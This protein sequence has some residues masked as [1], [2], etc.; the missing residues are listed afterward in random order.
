MMAN[1]V[2]KYSNEK[3]A[4]AKRYFNKIPPIDQ[5]K[6]QRVLRNEYVEKFESV[7]KAS[8]DSS[9]KV[10]YEGRLRYKKLVNELN[11]P[12]GTF[13]REIFTRIYPLK[14]YP[15][16]I[17]AIQK[18]LSSGV[19]FYDYRVEAYTPPGDFGTEIAWLIRYESL[20][21]AKS[22]ENAADMWYNKDEFSF[23]TKNEY[24]APLEPIRA[25]LVNMN[26]G[27]GDPVFV[28]DFVADAFES[29]KEGLAGGPE[30]FKITEDGVKVP[31]RSSSRLDLKEMLK[32]Y[33]P[34]RGARSRAHT[35]QSFA[36][37]LEAVYNKFIEEE[38]ATLKLEQYD[39]QFKRGLEYIKFRDKFLNFIN[40]N[41]L[42]ITFEEYY[43]RQLQDP[44]ITHLSFDVIDS[45]DISSDEQKIKFLEDPLYP[46]F[47]YQAKLN[48]FKIDPNNPWRLYAD[49]RSNRMEGFLKKRMK[50][51]SFT[52]PEVQ[53]FYFTTI[54]VADRKET[55]RN[56]EDG[57]P[58]LKETGFWGALFSAGEISIA[59]APLNFGSIS[60]KQVP[61][62]EN[63]SSVSE[64]NIIYDF[65]NLYLKFTARQPITSPVFIKE[66]FNKKVRPVEDYVSLKLAEKSKLHDKKSHEHLV[67]VIKS[68]IDYNKPILL[69]EEIFQDIDL[70]LTKYVTSKVQPAW[71]ETPAGV[72][73]FDR[74]AAAKH[75]VNV[76]TDSLVQRKTDKPKSKISFATSL[77]YGID[78]RNGPV[79]RYQKTTYQSAKF[80]KPN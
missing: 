5:R 14:E 48:G 77:K 57:T 33:R 37:H 10:T 12:R 16:S 20:N 49:I 53:D 42:A 41:K 73:E 38:I 50:K 28:F 51:A 4:A 40:K 55:P 34:K 78:N 63:N 19:G 46:L 79:D 32:K 2:D 74:I 6:E 26:E 29:F 7:S 11:Y 67:S 72:L 36:N 25:K 61:A 75:Y 22:L 58:I 15:T 43:S 66:Y 47:A 69:K 54:V 17:S 44:F 1:K 13:K 71:D 60:L 24:G 56:P 18:F 80:G 65:Y 45:T 30:L 9:S 59:T 23:L 62:F 76:Y 68:A 39:N 52:I 31:N 3:I 70:T 35:A 64:Q 8:N 27:G 21:L